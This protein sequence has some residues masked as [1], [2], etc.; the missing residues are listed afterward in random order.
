MKEHGTTLI[1]EPGEAV[2]VE[3]DRYEK[4][5]LGEKQPQAEQ[6]DSEQE[7]LVATTY[8]YPGPSSF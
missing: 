4:V 6:Q 5:K 1:L 7:V 8:P 3:R 2:L